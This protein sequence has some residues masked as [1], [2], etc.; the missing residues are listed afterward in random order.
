MKRGNAGSN[1]QR[2]DLQKDRRKSR[3]ADIEAS[4]A[5]LCKDAYFRSQHLHPANNLW[6]HSTEI[7]VLNA[8]QSYPV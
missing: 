4:A 6:G 1:Q 3:R 2:P 8:D 5:E 7:D